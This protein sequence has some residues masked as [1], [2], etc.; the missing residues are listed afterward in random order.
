MGATLSDIAGYRELIGHVQLADPRSGSLACPRPKDG[1]DY[2]P[3]LQ[4]LQAI[5]YAGGICLPA[6]ADAAGLAYCRSLWG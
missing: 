2:R 3:F 5:G 4:A 1:Y 6:D